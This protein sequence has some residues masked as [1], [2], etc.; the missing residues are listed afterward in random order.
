MQVLKDG[1]WHCYA[2]SLPAALK[3]LPGSLDSIL[4]GHPRPYQG[5]GA[6]S[7]IAAAMGS[8]Y[9]CAHRS[10]GNSAVVCN[11]AVS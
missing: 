1:L 2:L 11:F 3:P 8:R 10:S 9:S 4:A 7:N 5:K 6:A